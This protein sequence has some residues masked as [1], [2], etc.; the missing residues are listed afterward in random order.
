MK[1]ILLHS[2]LR[3]IINGAKYIELTPNEWAIFKKLYKNRKT[4]VSIQDLIWAIGRNPT[5]I[6]FNTINVHVSNIRRKF[7]T[8]LMRPMPIHAL[9]ND[10]FYYEERGGANE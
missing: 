8:V 2:S 6:C 3:R 9:L 4:V 5:K 1:S 7:K 10:G